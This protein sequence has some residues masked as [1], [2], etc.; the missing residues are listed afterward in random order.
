MSDAQKTYSE[1][2]ACFRSSSAH[3]TAVT[4]LTKTAFF[5]SF[6]LFL[7]IS[8]PK[9]QAIDPLRIIT[10]STI[11]YVERESGNG[12]AREEKKTIGAR[13]SMRFLADVSLSISHL[14]AVYVSFEQP[15]IARMRRDFRLDNA[16]DLVMTNLGRYRSVGNCRSGKYWIGSE[17][18]NPVAEAEN[19]LQVR[20]RCGEVLRRDRLLRWVV[21][22]VKAIDVVHFNS[23][24][25]IPNSLR[26]RK[27]TDTEF[28]ISLVFLNLS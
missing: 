25:W 11:S 22:G 18:R 5:P 12:N 8:A 28:L 23:L 13:N 7:Q 19:G 21:D 16:R 14:L 15:R 2:F 1:Y 17:P 10:N 20:L 26:N 6:L 3:I 4:K 24:K 27:N 9:L